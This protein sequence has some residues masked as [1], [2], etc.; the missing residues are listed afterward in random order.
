MMLKCL[1]VRI[2]QGQDDHNIGQHGLSYH[3]SQ[4]VLLEELASQ[5]IELASTHWLWPWQ[6]KFI[7][8]KQVTKAVLLT[9]IAS[10]LNV[11][12]G[13]EHCV[14]L[15]Y[16]QMETPT[17]RWQIY[18]VGQ[19]LV[20]GISFAVALRKTALVNEFQGAL[21]IAGEESGNLPLILAHIAAQ[22]KQSL[23][24][25]KALRKSMFMPTVTLI[26]GIGVSLLALL[27]LVPNIGSLVNLSG[28]EVPGATRFLLTLS[29]GLHLYTSEILFAFISACIGGILFCKSVKG[30]R[31]IGQCA[32]GIPVLGRLL[33]QQALFN[34]VQVLALTLKSGLPITRAL[35]I[36]ESIVSTPGLRRKLIAIDKA[37]SKGAT[38]SQAF[39]EAK[40][41]DALVIS[42]QIGE[43]TGDV[44][45][46]FENYSR[47]LE[48][49][50][51][52]T[53]E[54]VK[55]IVDPLATLFLASLVGSL[56][57]A[58][59]L[60]LMQMGSLV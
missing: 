38:I 1:P 16:S 55:Q 42:L 5:G 48:D 36:G 32:F 24:L 10:M 3:V 30:K 23:A 46:A 19:L 4:G 39:A 35:C 59:Y 14:R 41:P 44:S 43:N 58:I 17:L 21:L 33:Q 53:L 49:A 45:A 37:L 52:E 8:P 2:W 54:H 13:V 34:V 20:Q 47:L 40:F 7:I 9:N 56:V 57:V 12:L 18:N 25:S 26:A 50:T 22:D 51:S 27:W 11:G 31:L 6:R 60:P 28:K 15:V 29:D